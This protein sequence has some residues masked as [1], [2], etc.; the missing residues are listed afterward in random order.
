MA[1]KGEV[2]VFN[3]E[4]T[5]L[6]GPRENKSSMVFEFEHEVY[7]PYDREENKIQG[8]RRVSAFTITKD[9]DKLTPQLYEIVCKGR[10]CKKVEIKL[11]RIAAEGGD[12][13]EYFNY[14]LEDARII[15]VENLMPSTKVEENENIG[16]LEKVKFLARSFT[17]KFLEGGVEY[18]EISF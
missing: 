18:T 7:L 15:S 8:S 10:T 14:I 1:M 12:E 5:Q 13:E 2:L 4:N 6:E 17:W 9:I 16:H 3:H 11:Y